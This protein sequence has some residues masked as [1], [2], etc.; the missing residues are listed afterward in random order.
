M[1]ISHTT[2]ESHNRTL[3]E[4]RRTLRCTNKLK[5]MISKKALSSTDQYMVQNAN[6]VYMK[7]KIS[8]TLFDIMNSFFCYALANLHT[9]MKMYISTNT[10]CAALSFANFRCCCNCVL[11]NKSF[12]KQ[13]QNV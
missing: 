2:K 7:K 13:Q 5:E 3:L 12:Q 11:N 4:K 8:Y 10:T 6:P 9:M 1:T